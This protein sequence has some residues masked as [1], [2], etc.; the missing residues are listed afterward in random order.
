MGVEPI[1]G[2]HPGH[3]GTLFRIVVFRTVQ[4]R[5]G[6]ISKVRMHI[7]DAVDALSAKPN[8]SNLK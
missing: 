1:Q 5:G 4:F 2:P 3:N 6:K 7:H 8:Y